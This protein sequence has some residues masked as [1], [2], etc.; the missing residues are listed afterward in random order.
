MYSVLPKLIKLSGYHKIM[1]K[2]HK[3]IN[4]NKLYC[5]RHRKTRL[6]LT[7]SSIRKILEE[8]IAGSSMKIK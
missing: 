3:F 7:K 5:S 2:N 8:S 1:N 6:N 4:E